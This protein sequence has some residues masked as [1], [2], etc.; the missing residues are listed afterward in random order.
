M[1]LCDTDHSL[2]VRKLRD[3]SKWYKLVTKLLQN[4][5]MKSYVIYWMASLIDSLNEHGFTSAPTQYRLYGR[6]FLQVWWPNQQ[7][8]HFQ[9][10]RVTTKPG[11]QVL[12]GECLKGCIL[13]WPTADNPLVHNLQCT[14]L[15][16]C[17]PSA[18]AKPLVC[19]IKIIGYVSYLGARTRQNNR[20]CRTSKQGLTP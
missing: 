11:F 4:V 19:Y 14:V 2:A 18:I 5:N 20:D 15:L 17:G 3:T 9:W 12:K 13:N 7:W 8:R 1:L 16:M 6:R 10:P